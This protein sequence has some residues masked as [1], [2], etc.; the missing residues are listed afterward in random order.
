MRILSF[1]LLLIFSTTLL[2]F[3]CQKVN[4]VFHPGGGKPN[5]D[6]K[7]NTFKG[8][9]VAMGSGM[10]RSFIVLGH[11]GVPLRIGVEMTN[12]V[13]SGLPKTN[14]SVAIHCIIKLKKLR[15]S[16]ICI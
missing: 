3:S 1:R 4:D 8:P 10:A 15:H 5:E 13:L 16:I 2:L 7:Y 11:K 12:E 9:Q 14:F 6:T